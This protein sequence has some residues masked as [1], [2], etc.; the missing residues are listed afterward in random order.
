MQMLNLLANGVIYVGALWAL[1]T[2]RVPNRTGGA[3]ILGLICFAA[4]GNMVSP[5]SCHSQPEIALNVAVALGVLWC[6]WRLEL[7]HLFVH[8]KG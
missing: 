8:A 1:F 2:Q 6:F 4:L 5:G 3:L 7:R